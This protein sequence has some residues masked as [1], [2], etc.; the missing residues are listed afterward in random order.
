MYEQIND[1]L[2][3]RHGLIHR[4]E[5][6]DSYRTENLQRDIQDV[7]IAIKR[8]YDYLCQYYDWEKQELSL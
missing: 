5:I 6:D 3:R 1:I 4:L 7:T 8:V 2:E